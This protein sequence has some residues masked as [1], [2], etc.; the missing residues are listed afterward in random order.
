MVGQRVTMTPSRC[1]VA[2]PAELPD[3]TLSW[4]LWVVI[5]VPSVSAAASDD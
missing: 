3:S 2:R 4:A 5:F 1:T